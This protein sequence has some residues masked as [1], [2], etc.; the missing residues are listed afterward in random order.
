MDKSVHADSFRDLRVY[1]KAIQVE[2]AI[3]ALSRSFPIEERYSLTD[4]VRRSSRSVGAQIAEAWAK[5]RYVAH[6]TSKLTDADAEQMETQH[7]LEAA[8][9]AGYTSPSEIDPI[10]QELRDIGRMLNG[11][12]HKAALFCGSESPCVREGTTD[13]AAFLADHGSRITDHSLA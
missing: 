8:T 5:R 4:Q 12:I 9:R 7:W 2:G 6:F 11:M 3:M 1:Q 10:L 13:Y